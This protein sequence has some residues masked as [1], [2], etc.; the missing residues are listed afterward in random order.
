MC[1]SPVLLLHTSP[2]S[3]IP[4]VATNNSVDPEADDDNP[5]QVHAALHSTSQQAHKIFGFVKDGAGN[6]FKKIKDSSSTVV[7]QVTRFDSYH[8][9]INL[10]L[11]IL[12]VHIHVHKMNC[13]CMCISNSATQG[14]K[15]P[16]LDIA[17]IT[18]RILGTFTY[19]YVIS[20]FP[21]IIVYSGAYTCV[22]Y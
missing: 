1:L 19:M 20:V 21:S 22:M 14:S 16:P 12:I 15:R 4:S 17:Y 9:S 5:S 7:Q 18:S 6:L 13:M 2:S 3:H 8:V 10:V 11:Y